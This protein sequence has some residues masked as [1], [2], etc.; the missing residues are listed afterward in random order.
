[1]C[2]VR[3]VKSVGVISE[4]QIEDVKFQNSWSGCTL[5]GSSR[6]I[7]H[8]TNQNCISDNGVHAYKL[9]CNIL[10]LLH[11]NLMKFTSSLILQCEQQFEFKRSSFHKIYHLFFFLLYT[12]LNTEDLLKRH[13]FANCWYNYKTIFFNNFR[14][15]Q[16]LLYILHM[17]L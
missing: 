16:F 7:T 1:V 11:Q 5:L 10:I 15:S 4:V 17:H 6:N 14:H 13:L 2:F 8:H 3:D 9:M 12:V